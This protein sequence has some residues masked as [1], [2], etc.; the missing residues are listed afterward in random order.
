MVGVPEAEQDRLFFQRALGFMRE[1][2]GAIPGLVVW[3]DRLIV[4]L[5]IPVAA[6]YWG[7]GRIR[8]PADPVI[9]LVASYGFWVAFDRPRGPVERRAAART[10]LL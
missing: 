9:L 7:D 3:K 4:P 5:L 8:A 6:I 1:N 2:L 10:P